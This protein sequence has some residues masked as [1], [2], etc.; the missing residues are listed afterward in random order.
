MQIGLQQFYSKL[1]VTAFFLIKKNKICHCPWQRLLLRHHHAMMFTLIPHIRRM[2][3]WVDGNFELLLR[4]LSGSFPTFTV[5]NHR[6]IVKP[7]LARSPQHTRTYDA[8]SIKKDFGILLNTAGNTA[9]ISI[10]WDRYR[11]WSHSLTCNFSQV[12]IGFM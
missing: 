6:F 12:C 8:Q 11:N 5:T 2:I 7:W 10:C 4:S 9:I 3:C 1:K